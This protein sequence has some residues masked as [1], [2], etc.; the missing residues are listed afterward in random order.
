MYFVHYPTN[1]Y[2]Q[3]LDI[4]SLTKT[5]SPKTSSL[6]LA[7]FWHPKRN[8]KQKEVIFNSLGIN[9]LN[10]N[11]IDYCFEYPTPAYE[12][13]ESGKTLQYSKPSMTDLMFFLDKKA[14]ITLEAKYTEY[15]NDE[16]YAPILYDWNDTSKPHRK[17]IIECWID[18][19]KNS[20]CSTIKSAD[21]L[22]NDERIK[23]LPY[24]FLHR[25]ASACFR[26]EKPIL[27]Y[28]LFYDNCKS[29]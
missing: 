17:K 2:D 15:V 29:S 7:D 18:Y 8:D 24:Q 16:L 19:I 12:N 14:R 10:Q 1:S 3:T 21:D 11:N 23:E 9:N 13:R 5:N 25:T 27:V 26:C 4:L 22:L 28:Q 6:P 20:G